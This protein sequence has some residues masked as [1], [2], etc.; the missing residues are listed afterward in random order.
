[1]AWGMAS[2]TSHQ[3]IAAAIAGL[4]APAEL[5]KQHAMR[6]YRQ[7]G[8]KEIRDDAVEGEMHGN[9]K[10]EMHAQCT[11]C[12]SEGEITIDDNYTPKDLREKGV[13]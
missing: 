11:D 3:T 10:E 7:K 9:A 12:D 4:P 6:W 1:M 2:S 13:I 8:E 5:E